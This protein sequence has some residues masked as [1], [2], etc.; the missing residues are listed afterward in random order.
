MMLNIGIGVAVLG[1]VV[2]GI[3]RLSAGEKAD[4]LINEK[5]GFKK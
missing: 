2:Y 1:G 5:F 3:Y 4:A